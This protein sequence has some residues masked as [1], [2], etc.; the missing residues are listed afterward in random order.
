M[1][2]PKKEISEDDVLAAILKVKP[3]EDMPRSKS[4]PKPKPEQKPPKGGM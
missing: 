2:K 1:E 4:K 3:T